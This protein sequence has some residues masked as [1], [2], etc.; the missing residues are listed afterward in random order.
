MGMLGK[1]AMNREVNS[2]TGESIGIFKRAWCSTC[3]KTPKY[4]IKNKQFEN[5]S[6]QGFHSPK[7]KLDREKKKLHAIG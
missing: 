1:G 4:N 2:G 7:T 3:N 5:K 6:N